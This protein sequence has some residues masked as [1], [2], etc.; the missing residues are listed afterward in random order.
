MPIL[1]TL[2]VL[3]L[4]QQVFLRETIIFLKQK[5]LILPILSSQS[6]KDKSKILLAVDLNT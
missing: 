5:R 1:N 3:H 4:R 2:R 6:K